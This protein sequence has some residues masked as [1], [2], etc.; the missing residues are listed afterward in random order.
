MNVSEM[1]DGIDASTVETIAREILAWCEEQTAE[2]ERWP[3]LI[4][5]AGDSGQIADPT[6]VPQTVRADRH[7]SF[8]REQMARMLGQRKG[9]RWASRE[10]GMGVG[11]FSPADITPRQAKSLLVVVSRYVARWSGPY[12]RRPLSAEGREETVAAILHSIWTRDY[13]KS[14]IARGNLAA[15]TWQTCSLYRRT[16]WVGDSL[17]ARAAEKRRQSGIESAEYNRPPIDNPAR[18]AEAIEA[19]TSRYDADGRQIGGLW[20]PS[21]VNRARKTSRRSRGGKR[22]EPIA[23]EVARE[24]IVG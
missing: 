9:G 22:M 6:P 11:T 17:F 3:L 14:G 23:A 2:R 16:A 19:A 5:L 24:A 20:A 12:D 7:R 15:A 21:V 18:I 13:S 1:I 4:P 10:R 8:T